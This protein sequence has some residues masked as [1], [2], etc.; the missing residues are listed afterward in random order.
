MTIDVLALV[1]VTPDRV[2]ALTAAGYAVREGKTYATRI[3]AMRAAAATVRAVLTNGRG[4][5]SGAEMALLPKLELICAVGAGYEAV[6][7]ATAR[8]RGIVVAH[9]PDAN[10][11]AVADSAMLL[12]AVTRHLLEA[13]RF[14]RAGGW[15]EQWR[16][17]TP[18]LTGKRLGLLGLGRIGSRIAQ[19]AAHGFDMAIGS[20]TRTA[21]A[22]TPYRAFAS[23]VELA[24]WADFFVAAAPGGA[25]TRHL[26]NAEVSPR[27]GRRGISSTSGAG[28]SWRPTPG[29][30]RCDQSS[31]AGARPGCPGGGTG[32]PAS[33]PGAVAM[34]QRGGDAACRR[35]RAG[36]AERSDRVDAGQP[37]CACCR[38]AAARASRQPGL[39]PSAR[40]LGQTGT[41]QR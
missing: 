29:S 18:T 39:S 24:T 26:I 6:D 30:P 5:L 35:A 38:P 22:G 11:P 17:E 3:D 8:R 7:L 16:V 32:R 14:V 10:A 12:L 9:C 1:G 25:G 40:S 36:V 21:V 37:A 33:P 28:R 19:R 4:G 23:L 2:A 15:Q 41:A 34:R 20:H 31:I 13:D 27:S